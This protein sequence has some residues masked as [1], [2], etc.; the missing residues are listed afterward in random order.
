MSE[1]HLVCNGAMCQCKFGTTPDKLKVKQTDYYINDS[2][3]SQ[4]SIANTMD[5]GQP[6][7]AN[8]FGSCKKM[9]NNP[10]KPAITEWKDFYDKVTL[11]NGGK[12]LLENSKATCT[13][14]G[15]PCVDITF[16]GQTAAVAAQN[17]A[18]AK[19]E[20]GSQLNPLVNLKTVEEKQPVLPTQT[21]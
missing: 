1:K 11:Q 20:V 6:F 3:G 13:V 17:T 7:Q 15:S 12:I 5:I 21:Q 19:E 8:T 9:N 2:D 16:H 14:G 4:K 18:K 10:C